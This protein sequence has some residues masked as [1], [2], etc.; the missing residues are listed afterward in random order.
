MWRGGLP[1]RATSSKP[2]NAPHFRPRPLSLPSSSSPTQLCRRRVGHRFASSLFAQLPA[3]HA[4]LPG[5]AALPQW[6]YYCSDLTTKY[7][8]SVYYT[9]TTMTTTGFGDVSGGVR[10]LFF[11]GFRPCGWV[12]VQHSE[13][14]STT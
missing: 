9:L 1:L 4:T 8:F 12:W 14:L 5:A 10:L 6:T 7:C 2:R 13:S 3:L 11:P